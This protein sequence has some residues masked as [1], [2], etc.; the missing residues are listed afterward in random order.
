MGRRYGTHVCRHCGARGDRT[1]FSA[2]FWFVGVD[3]H[4]TAF[5]I[6]REPTRGDGYRFGLGPFEYEDAEQRAYL[7]NTTEVTHEPGGI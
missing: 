6:P 7:W 4:G 5:V 1:D 2:R 3:L